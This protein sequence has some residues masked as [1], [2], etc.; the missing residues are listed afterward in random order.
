MIRVEGE[1]IL[2]IPDMFRI[3]YIEGKAPYTYYRRLQ[4]F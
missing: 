4:A 1:V 3:I 2:K